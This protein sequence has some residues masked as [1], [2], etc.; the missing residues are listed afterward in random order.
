MTN[1]KA[2]IMRINTIM[3]WSILY[4]YSCISLPVNFGPKMFLGLLLLLWKGTTCTQD[5]SEDV[6]LSN[7]GILKKIYPK[8]Y[9]YF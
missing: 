3:T 1:V 8:Q 4:G 5:A 2:H 9:Y 7:K 6:I